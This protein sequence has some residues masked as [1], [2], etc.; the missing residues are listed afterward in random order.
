MNQIRTI[1]LLLVYERFQNGATSEVGALFFLN[2]IIKEKK[3]PPSK[4]CKVAP[5]ST[6]F[7]SA[8][9][10]AAWSLGGSLETPARWHATICIGLKSIIPLPQI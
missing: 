8:C 1:S 6:F 5:F 3:A 10:V 2:M 7:L 4:A 9:L